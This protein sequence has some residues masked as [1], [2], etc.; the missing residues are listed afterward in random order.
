MSK[1]TRYL[2]IEQLLNMLPHLRPAGICRTGCTLQAAPPL[3]A[4]GRGVVLTGGHQRLSRQTTNVVARP[5]LRRV[6]DHSVRTKSNIADTLARLV[7]EVEQEA[8]N[9]T[10]DFT[11]GQKDEGDS[12]NVS[13]LSEGQSAFQVD[14]RESAKAYQCIADL[15]G[16]AKEHIQVSF[17]C[18]LPATKVKPRKYAL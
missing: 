10:A 7:H 4:K 6:L 8:K 3:L 11:A 15:P 13:H 2:S 18:C 5:K 12:L 9:F 1:L 17:E 16:V 14:L